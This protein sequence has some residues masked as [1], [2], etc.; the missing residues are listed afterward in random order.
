MCDKI[1]S[2][3]EKNAGCFND[4]KKIVG[5]KA[6]KIAKALQKEIDSGAALK[7]EK[8]YNHNLNSMEQVAC[9][10]CY[11]T[12]VRN[13]AYVKG[14]CNGC[15][16]TGKTD[17]FAKSYPFSVDNVKEFIEFCQDSGG[18]RIC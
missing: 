18:F 1:L 7:Y 3:E 12:G 8:E 14:K 9:P 13:D 15:D 16:G 4:G 10:H 5:K 11:A 6:E 17:P 2:E